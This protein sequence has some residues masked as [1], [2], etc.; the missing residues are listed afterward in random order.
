MVRQVEVTLPR[1]AGLRSGTVK[2]IAFQDLP[3]RAVGTYHAVGAE[4][5]GTVGMG[6]LS[7][8][9]GSG[10]DLEVYGYAE[11]ISMFNRWVDASESLDEDEAAGAD[12]SW[13][14]ELDWNE[15]L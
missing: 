2:A 4:L 11:L 13:S 14:S 3:G 5:K 7:L 10:V 8:A 9:V 15:I 6:L 1:V 12:A